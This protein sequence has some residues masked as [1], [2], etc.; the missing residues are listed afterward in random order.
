MLIA[1]D[2][3]DRSLLQHEPPR[4]LP[5]GLFVTLIL[6]YL[7][8]YPLLIFLYLLIY[9]TLALALGLL[10]APALLWLFFAG[11]ALAH[12]AVELWKLGR[13]VH[14]NATLLKH[15]KV[16]RAHIMRLRI[17]EDPQDHSPQAFLDCAIPVTRQRTSIGSVG[18]ADVP[19][20][21]RLKAKGHVWVVCLTHAPGTWMLVEGTGAD[22]LYEIPEQ[23]RVQ[24]A[25]SEAAGI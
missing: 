11:V 18:F 20:A 8:Y 12:L 16:L 25:E 9:N 2:Y 15:G 19:M 1:T 10:Q 4:A 17:L 5:S 22:V 7:E 14:E 6:R 3:I 23:Q 13:Y 21:Q 24:L